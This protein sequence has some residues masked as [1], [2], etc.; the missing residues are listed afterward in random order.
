MTFG[1]RLRTGLDLVA[2]IF[3]DLHTLANN[4]IAMGI[5]SRSSERGG[6]N[7]Y[8]RQGK[9]RHAT[10]GCKRDAGNLE[11][12]IFGH[13]KCAKLVAIFSTL[14]RGSKHVGSNAHAPTHFPAMPLMEEGAT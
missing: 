1:L 14:T 5:D 8:A 2:A 9:S 12:G 10:Q 6:A 3:V 13:A 11:S 4:G 7:E